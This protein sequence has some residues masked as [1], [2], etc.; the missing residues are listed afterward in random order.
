MLW[1]TLISF[2]QDSDKICLSWT[3]ISKTPEEMEP[4]SIIVWKCL[5]LSNR[6]WGLLPTPRRLSLHHSITSWKKKKKK[7]K[8]RKLKILTPTKRGNSSLQLLLHQSLPVRRR[9]SSLRRRKRSRKWQ[10]DCLVL[11]QPNQGRDCLALLRLN[12]L[13]QRI[14]LSQVHLLR[15]HRRNQLRSQLS[16]KRS[17]P[18]I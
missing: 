8:R 11:L 3:N 5:K 13:R 9:S 12:Q 18:L 2:N 10:R 7:S 1:E 4:S 15:K 6:S 16:L 14:L 17:K